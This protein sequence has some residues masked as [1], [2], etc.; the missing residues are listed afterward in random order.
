MKNITSEDDV[1]K[2]SKFAV[3]INIKLRVRAECR[4]AAAVITFALIR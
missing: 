1:N 3:A 2:I 4:V